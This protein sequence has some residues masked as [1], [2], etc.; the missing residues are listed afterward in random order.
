MSAPGPEQILDA[1]HTTR[2]SG[3]SI[4]A[5]PVEWTLRPGSPDAVARCLEGARRAG[6][7]V[8]AWGAGTKQAGLNPLAASSVWRVDLRR[9]DRIL[10]LDADEGVVVAQA[11]VPVA[12]LDAAARGAG[13]RLGLGTVG[14]PAATL[15][16][17]FSADPL[18]PEAALDRRPAYE[19]LGVEAA[20]CDGSLARAGGRVVKNVTGFDLVRLYAGSFGTLGVVT[21][22]ALRLRPAPEAR[23]VLDLALPDLQA[24]IACGHDLRLARALPEGLA[25]LPVRRGEATVRVLL[26][27]SRADVAA[28]AAKLGGERRP[29]SAWAALAEPLWR[30][31]ASGATRLRL[32]GRPSDT[33]EIGAAIETRA[34]RESV[35]LA[36]PAAGIALAEVCDPATVEDLW[37]LAASRDWALR[38]EDAPLE[39]RR[40]LDVFG[41]EPQAL[42]LMRLLKRRF[43]PERT[44]APGRFVG[45]L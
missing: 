27:G 26:E 5:V 24:A 18:V 43:D 21:E 31:P 28:R 41:P 20:L 17:T 35:R 4:D 3:A 30:A 12:A 2:E 25:V 22:L 44:L 29:E 19:A 15:G 38:I 16:G 42:P 32:A 9:L 45:R 10:D 23:E 6:R 40:K 39:L 14:P 13:K 11:G 36:F 33:G 7:A 8:V 37:Q 1:E 34:G